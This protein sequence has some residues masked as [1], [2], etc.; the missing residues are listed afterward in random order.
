MPE[1]AK[2]E[3]PHIR[4]RFWRYLTIAIAILVPI[5][6]IHLFFPKYMIPIIFALLLAYMV[7]NLLRG[8]GINGLLVLSLLTMLANMLAPLAEAIA[9]RIGVRSVLVDG[10]L[11]PGII[12][13][14]L[15]TSLL[16]TKSQHA[17]L[18]E[19]V[20]ASTPITKRWQETGALKDAIIALGTVLLL[21]CIAQLILDFIEPAAKLTSSALG[22]TVQPVCMLLLLLWFAI[23]TGRRRAREK[24]QRK[25]LSQLKTQKLFVRR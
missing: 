14:L 22:N 23:S 10:A 4:N 13:I 16:S 18:A 24:K 25:S 12:G 3:P 17:R 2:P 20:I 15:L 8:R 19:K 11:L 1:N 7:S 5:S 9:P 6:I 21:D